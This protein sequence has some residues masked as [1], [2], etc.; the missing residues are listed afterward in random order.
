MRSVLKGTTHKSR[1]FFFLLPLQYGRQYGTIYTQYK[2]QLK[3]QKMTTV[4]LLVTSL[5]LGTLGSIL[6][7]LF[8]KENDLGTAGS[9]LF[10]A[11][12]SLFAGA[13]LV[14]WGGNSRNARLAES[15]HCRTV[16]CRMYDRNRLCTQNRADSRLLRVQKM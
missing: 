4:L 8:M 6:R 12:C 1:I 5:V 15:M 3:G 16:I 2:L 13:V 7:K 11:I 10:T 14:F 9:F